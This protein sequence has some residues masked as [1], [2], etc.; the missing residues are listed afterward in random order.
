[1]IIWIWIWMLSCKVFSDVNATGAP[2][3]F[4]VKP[5]NQEYPCETWRNLEILWCHNSHYHIGLNHLSS[6]LKVGIGTN[7]ILMININI[8]NVFYRGFLLIQKKIKISW[9]GSWILAAIVP[10]HQLFFITKSYEV[11]CDR[12]IGIVSRRRDLFLCSSNLPSHSVDW[13]TNLGPYYI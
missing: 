5:R 3:P 12:N 8:N 2:P 4:P 10:R 9:D 1:M 7:N 13:T 11:L 6:S